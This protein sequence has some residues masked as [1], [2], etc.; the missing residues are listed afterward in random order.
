MRVRYVHAKSI[1]TPQRSGFLH[2][3]ERP[4]THSLS[5]AAGCGLGKLYCGTYCYARQLPNWQFAKRADED[6]GEAMVVKINAPQ[7]LADSLR[8]SSQRRNLRVFCSPVTDPWQPIERKLRITRQCLEVFAQ[9]DDLDLLLMQTRSPTAL[10]DIDLLARIP[11]A[12]LGM[13]IET[14]RGDLAYGPTTAHIERRFAAVEQAVASGVRAQIAVSPCLPHTDNFARRLLDTGAQRI[15]IDTFSAGDGRNG[16]RTAGS[17]FALA[18]DY[19]W[20]DDAVARALCEALRKRH[21]GVGW[22]AAGFAG[23][24]NQNNPNPS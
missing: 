11:Y 17:P 13:T 19:D 15:V 5:W 8:K 4:F 24:S 18:A 22:S 20:R 1:L 6:W 9:H 10:D 7:L 16:M 14:D 21:D 3:G 2:A 23:I 12:W